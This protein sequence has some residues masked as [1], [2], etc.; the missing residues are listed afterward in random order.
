M[1]DQAE[2]GP[3][4]SSEIRRKAEV[5]ALFMGGDYNMTVGVGPWGSGWHWD[6]VKNHVS[7][8]AK[9]LATESEDVVKG[10]ASH[11]G[12]HRLVSRAEHVLDLWQEPGFSFG[13][14][15]CED[16]RANQAGM[17]MRPGSRDWIQAYIERDLNPGGG[18]DY[19]GMQEQAKGTLG[20]VPKFM[21]WGG[22]MIHYWYEKEFKNAQGTPEALQEFV[23][24]IPD[25]DVRRVF[26]ETVQDFDN[27]YQ[28][29]PKTKDEFDIQREAIASSSVYKDK[30]WPK[31]KELVDKSVK[32]QS[33]ANM[34]KDMLANDQGQQGQT[35]QPNQGS[36]GSQ[37]TMI[38]FES[39]PQEVQDEIRKKV[40]EAN[41]KNQD[42]SQNKKG[43][44]DGESNQEN[45]GK[46]GQEGKQSQAEQAGRSQSQQGQKGEQE[47]QSQDSEE[48]SGQSQQAQSS[49]S[50][51]STESSQG[52]GEVSQGQSATN[53]HAGESTEQENKGSASETSPNM[54]IP[55]DD[56]SK[57]T[58]DAVKSVFDQLPQSQKDTLQEKAK[59]DLE[60]VED[61]ANEKLKGHMNDPKHLESHEE[62]REREENEN[63]RQEQQK[64]AEKAV[65]E[66]ER[67][68]EEAL[69][70]IPANYYQEFLAL[71]EV[72]AVRRHLEKEFKALFEPTEKPT[73]RYSTSGLQPSMKKA[74]QMEADP[75]KNQAFEIKGRP[76]EKSYRFELVIDLSPSMQDKIEETFK[77]VVA[78][79]EIMNR[80]GLE[81]AIVGFADSF[82]N[83]VKLYKDFAK[84]KLTKEDRDKIGEMLYDCQRGSGTPTHE[85]TKAGYE[86]LKKRM[87]LLPRDNNFFITLTDGQPTST[88]SD[89]V[90]QLLQKVRKDKSVVTA[91]FG[92]GPGTDFVNST[93]PTLNERIK[94]AIARK[95]GKSEGQV[96]NSYKNAEEFGV[97]FAIIMEYM[98]K[99]PELFYK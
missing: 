19:K 98:V 79:S 53:N 34:I 54:K 5:I 13:F 4:I 14:N 3:Q 6:F 27:F 37:V 55:W 28:I 33:L 75:R 65:K 9:D 30:I 57:K 50:D 18:L 69:E 81:F 59:R 61:E 99:H 23:D 73:I 66:M 70:R 97:A 85:A 2:R 44:A 95:I 72:D 92:I 11:E 16:P 96:G 52:K 77:M 90:L 10:V 43:S 89:E 82:P 71:P 80:F 93:Y 12:N 87:K 49:S 58:K 83:S 36:G 68:R 76:T 47:E 42:S 29:I 88:S 60:N 46:H 38:P 41:R 86:Y 24:E 78:F 8:D 39:L 25:K 63:L 91:G 45:Q 51:Q 15:T 94:K 21:Q 74:M 20:Y 35:D 84:K 48:K 31:Y 26:T 64:Q 32:D 22:E 62:R 1:N 40:Q 17:G 7:M 67:K 56:L